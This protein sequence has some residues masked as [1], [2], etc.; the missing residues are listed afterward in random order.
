MT[1]LSTLSKGAFLS[2]SAKLLS[3]FIGLISTLILARLLTPSDFGVIAAVSIALYF[4]DVLGNVATEQYIMQ[5]HRLR[6][7]D[8]DTAWTIN[9]LLK[10]FICFVLAG[11]SGVIAEVLNKPE[12]ATGLIVVSLI[13][14]LNALKSPSLLQQKRMVRYNGIFALSIAEKL[15]AFVTVISAA[16]LLKN[17]WAFIIADLAAC[18]AGVILSYVWFKKLPHYRLSAWRDQ[19][20]FSSWMLGKNLVGYLRSQ[21]D[22][23]FV[24]RY[25]AADTLGQYHLSRELAMMP[26]HYLLAPALEPVLSSLRSTV[27]IRDYF[28]QQ[29]STAVI[30]TLMISLPI[31]VFISVFSEPIALTLLG[32]QWSTAGDVLRILSWLVVYWGVI[33]VLEIALIAQG[34]VKGLF[35]FD[36]LTL[37]CILAVLGYAFSTS[38]DIASVAFYRVIAGVATTFLLFI[39]MYQ[40]YLAMAASVFVWAFLIASIAG[41]SVWI[42]SLAR[43]VFVTNNTPTIYENMFVLSGTCVCFSLL[44]I[45]GMGAILMLLK[46]T[47][48]AKQ[49]LSIIKTSLGR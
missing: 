26:G 31:A 37:L 18:F 41:L 44:F 28:Y 4:F 13:M 34:K 11:A 49:I 47:K 36:M 42:A 1:Q 19:F 14:P 16:L 21:A 3:K 46:N 2:A 15:I 24:S 12:I 6:A 35:A 48:T 45:I 40:A 43:L 10:C 30:I 39:I 25:F 7:G 8:L 20:T 38:A 33:Y 17:F 23:I 29:V 9:L 27:H 5:K 32:N 22:T